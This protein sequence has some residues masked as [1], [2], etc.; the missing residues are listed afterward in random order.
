M[1]SSEDIHK[2]ITSYNL[3]D[4]RQ[5]YLGSLGSHSA[6]DVSSGAADEGLRTVVTCKKGKEKSYVHH[7]NRQRGW[8]YVGC[9]DKVILLNNWNQLTSEEVQGTLRRLK[10]IF[11]PSR[12]M[13]VYLG[14]DVIENQFK[15]PLLGNREVL[16][17]EERTGPYLIKNGHNQ[18]YFIELAGLPRP[19]KFSSPSEINTK[20]MVKA[21]KAIGERHF[22]RAGDPFS[23]ENLPFPT[24]SSPT[25]YDELCKKMM[26][27]GKTPEERDV[28]E[29]NFKGATIEEF[30]PGKTINMNFFQSVMNKDDKPYHGLELLGCDTRMQFPN[31]EE[32]V[33]VVLSL[34]ESKLEDVMD[35]G[36]RFVEAV[37]KEYKRGII[38]PF[39]LQTIGNKEEKFAVIDVS[40]RIPGSPDTEITPYT[41]Y[42]F[43]EPVSFGRRIAMEIKEAILTER[44]EE[45]VS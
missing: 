9:I 38:G 40:P 33:H 29:K 17:I 32:E 44:L 35:M 1:I 5:V 19:K 36:M 20:V 8:E 13:E 24:V 30:L 25:E 3:K 22:Q 45:I 10:T 41:K 6:L 15:V 37:K 14:H 12:S 4:S 42:F 7:L 18:D 28:I 26:E 39:A 11:V 23:G 34:R 43:R 21:T 16:R 2:I 27:Q 31:G